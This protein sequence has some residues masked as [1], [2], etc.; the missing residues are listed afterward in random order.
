MS[1]FSKI[2]LQPQ[3]YIQH[4]Q[5]AHGDTVV[6]RGAV[7]DCTGTRKPMSLTPG[8]DVMIGCVLGDEEC[9]AIRDSW[10]PSLPITVIYAVESGRSVNSD[11]AVFTS[12]KADLENAA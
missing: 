12:A 4:G 2:R 6:R 3:P 7:V 1:A 8:E 10:Q 11:P 9:C 5:N